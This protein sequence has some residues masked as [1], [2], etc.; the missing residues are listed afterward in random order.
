MAFNFYPGSLQWLGLARET[1]YGVAVAAPTIWI[2]VDGPKWSPKQTTL[3]DQN[4]RG[5]MGDAYGQQLGS[6]YDEVSYK[7][8]IY[9]DSIMAHFRAILGGADTV[10]GAADPY[11]HKVALSNGSGTDGAQPP[12]YTVFLYMGNGKSKQ[13][14]GCV[15]G[16]LK[17]TGKANE[18]PTIDVTWTG[19]QAVD[20]T[21][22]TNTPSTA[23]PMPPQTMAITVGGTNLGK[24]SDLSIGYK[25]DIKPILTLNGSSAPQAIY[26]G[27]LEVTGSFTAVWQGVTDTDLTNFLTNVQPALSVVINPAGD[28]VHTF[29]QQCSK[30]AYDSA[31][32]QP[33]SSDWLTLSVAFKALMNTTDAIGGGQ[34]PAQAILLNTA[35]ATL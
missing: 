20:I 6:R 3:T 19:L 12:S 31:D 9:Q 33:S 13:I 2:P 8:Y 11:T 21:A 17:F 34:S 5:F 29:T 25:R 1:T 22:P 16:D 30:I 23:A 14:P 15:L 35:A 4:L 32:P 28:S 26:V 7:T 27:Q 24:Y 18:L 10:T